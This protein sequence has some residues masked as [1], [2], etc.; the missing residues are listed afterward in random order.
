MPRTVL[1]DKTCVKLLFFSVEVT[2]S[3]R[4]LSGKFGHVVQIPVSR[5]A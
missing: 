2:N 1:M 3:K 4:Q 5:L